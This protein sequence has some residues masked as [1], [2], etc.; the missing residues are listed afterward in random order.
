MN[1]INEKKDVEK[2]NRDETLGKGKGVFGYGEHEGNG[3][4]GL[5]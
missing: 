2:E 4:Y 5:I 1:K 3:T